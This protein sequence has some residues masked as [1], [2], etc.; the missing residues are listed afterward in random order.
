MTSATA[1][2]RM[3]QDCGVGDRGGN[4][5]VAIGEGGDLWQ[6]GSRRTVVLVTVDGTRG[7]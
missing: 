6:K 5:I 3:G 4:S 2:L 7:W 1:V